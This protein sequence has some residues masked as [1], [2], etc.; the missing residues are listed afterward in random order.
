MTFSNGQGAVTLLGITATLPLYRSL[1]NRRRLYTKQ[2]IGSANRTMAASDLKL[3]GRGFDWD[4]EDGQNTSWS[5]KLDM[6]I[7]VPLKC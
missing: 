4:D 2:V 3:V 1:E 6:S 5:F 7:S